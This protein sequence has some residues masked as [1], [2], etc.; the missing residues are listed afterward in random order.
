MSARTDWDLISS[1]AGLLSLAASIIYSGS[2]GSLPVRQISNFNVLWKQLRLTDH[3]ST[4]VHFSV[5]ADG[6]VI[7]RSLNPVRPAEE[8]KG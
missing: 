8:T 2:Y 1:Y 5:L 3:L 7:A 4:H 6:C